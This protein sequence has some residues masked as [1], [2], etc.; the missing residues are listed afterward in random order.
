MATTRFAELLERHVQ[1]TVQRKFEHEK[2]DHLT[3]RKI[4]QTIREIIAGVF[5]RSTHKLTETAQAWLT[6]Q[7]FKRL[8]VG[9]DVC[10]ADLIITNE[11]KLSQLETSDLRL[12]RELFDRTELAG[13]LDA[14]L[15]V[16]SAT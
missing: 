9:P 8:Q 3:M 12:M 4:R 16:R 2:L 11:H 13:E 1:H 14:E 7:I 6:D 5:H 15:S 10:M